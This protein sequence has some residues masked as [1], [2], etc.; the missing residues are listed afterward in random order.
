MA[1]TFFYAPRSSATRVLWALEELGVPF[2][3]VRVDLSKGEQ[4]KPDF[5]A[6]NPNGKVPAMIDGDAKLFESLAILLHLGDR[7][8]AAKRLWPAP[9]TAERAEA[10]AWAV[11]GTVTVLGAALTH[12]THTNSGSAYAPAAEHGSP[13]LAADS[14]KQWET[15]LEILDA[16]LERQPYVVGDGFTLVDVANASTIAFGSMAAKLPLDGCR[17][18]QAWIERCRARPA[19]TRAMNG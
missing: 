8:G 15:C 14:K 4:K 13:E 19:F 18:V 2:E 12:A 10:F 5:L 1:M 7:Y 6:I 16:R 11:W 9:G 17:N 3:K